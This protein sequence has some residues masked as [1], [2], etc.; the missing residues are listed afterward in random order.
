M[1][2]VPVLVLAAAL[3]APSVQPA[4]V[5]ASPVPDLEI[6]HA[7]DVQGYLDT[8]G[9]KVNPSGGLPRRGWVASQV[10]TLFPDA[11][12]VLLDAGNFSDSPT[13]DGEAK[14]R[15][16]VEGMNRLGYAAANV[17]ERELTAG[18]PG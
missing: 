11:A 15:A 17:G 14:T 1:L 16:L 13:S 12:V 2:H 3:A 9:C 7:G 5:P 18:F 4:L 8:C 10:R 6:L